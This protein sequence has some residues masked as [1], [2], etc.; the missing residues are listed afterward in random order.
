[1]LH[2]VLWLGPKPLPLNVW[3]GALGRISWVLTSCRQ[4]LCFLDVATKYFSFMYQR[5]YSVGSA[6]P[7]TGRSRPVSPS[8]AQAQ[9]KLSSSSAIKFH[10]SPE[11]RARR[12]LEGAF[13][14]RFLGQNE[15]AYRRYKE[16]Q[17]IAACDDGT[18]APLFAA[19]RRKGNKPQDATRWGETFGTEVRGLCVRRISP[20]AI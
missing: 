2:A 18:C 17:A 3:A 11:R 5:T 9:L 14:Q 7:A 10:G 1:M 13:V 20:C 8:L 6:R 15:L 4:P 16:R 12:Y 19:H